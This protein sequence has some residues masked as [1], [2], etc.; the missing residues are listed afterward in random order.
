MF[1]MNNIIEINPSQPGCHINEQCTGVWPETR[2]IRGVC[3]CPE[4]AGSDG[5][6]TRSV[7]TRDGNVCVVPGGTNFFHFFHFFPQISS[8]K[9]FFYLGD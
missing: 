5:K 1:E 8:W 2:C 6:Q 7:P 4:V 9:F 3:E